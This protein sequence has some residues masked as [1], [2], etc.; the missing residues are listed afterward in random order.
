MRYKEAM[1]YIVLTLLLAACGQKALPDP[2]TFRP[3]PGEPGERFAMR[4]EHKTI[5]PVSSHQSVES[6]VKAGYVDEVQPEGRV[7]RID[8]MGDEKHRF[9]L[10]LREG[11]LVNELGERQ[12][13]FR[14]FEAL[15]PPRPV[16]PNDRWQARDFWGTWGLFP[17]GAPKLKSVRA[18]CVYRGAAGQAGTIHVEILAE[19]VKGPW[20]LEGDLT[21]DL[22]AEMLVRVELRG[23]GGGS[24]H[25]MR[26]ERKFLR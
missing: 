4:Y 1:R 5:H 17:L 13:D 16:R 25:E 10:T 21:Y 8:A 3:R 24:R 6:S 15:L 22:G 26:L 20:A 11:R 14:Q 7:I 23:K 18:A 19:T 2:V 9:Q 12:D